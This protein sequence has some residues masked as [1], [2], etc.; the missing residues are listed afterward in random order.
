MVNLRQRP[1]AV[2]E[3][4]FLLPAVVRFGREVLVPGL[5]AV[6][7]DTGQAGHATYVLTA[8]FIVN[9]SA[10]C[11]PSP[12]GG[13]TTMGEGELGLANGA[14]SRAQQ[15]GIMLMTATT[16]VVVFLVYNGTLAG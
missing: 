11:A 8:A 1:G 7:G 9:A 3:I 2:G 4:H 16:A 6:T 15:A 10:S 12:L 14:G 13:I 5:A